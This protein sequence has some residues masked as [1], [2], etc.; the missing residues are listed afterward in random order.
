MQQQSERK[1]KDCEW[2]GT[3]CQG[4]VAD[5]PLYPVADNA[6]QEPATRRAPIDLALER[7]HQVAG[8]RIELMPPESEIGRL[9]LWRSTGQPVDVVVI[10]EAIAVRESS[11]AIATADFLPEEGQRSLVRQD[12]VQH[13]GEDALAAFRLLDEEEPDQ[14]TD[15]QIE[16]LVG[17]PDRGRQSP[18]GLAHDAFDRDLALVMNDLHDTL[19]LEPEVRAQDAVP[20]YDFIQASLQCREVELPGEPESAHH[21]VGGGVRLELVLQPEAAL[22][23]AEPCGLIHRPRRY[24]RPVDGVCRAGSPGTNRRSFEAN[25]ILESAGGAS[26]FAVGRHWWSPG[27]IRMHLIGRRPVMTARRAMVRLTAGTMSESVRSP[28]RILEIETFGRGGLA[29]YAFNL[30][31]ALAE[32]GHEVTLVTAAGFELREHKGSMG[33]EIVEAL[34]RAGDRFGSLLPA[35][36]LPLLRK[37]EAIF[38]AF[39]VIRLARRL[40]PDVIH[41]HCTNQIALLYVALLRRLSTVLV[42]TAHVVMPHEPVRFQR[43]IYRRIH[44][45][46]DLI[47]AHSVFDRRRLLTEFGVAPERVC[48]IPHGEYSFFEHGAPVDRMTARQG[49]GLEPQHEVALFFGYIREYKGLDI[50]LEAWPEVAQ[51]RPEARLVVAGDP[52]QLDPERCRE[53]QQWAARLGV[54]H[55]FG[56][57]PF[58]DVQRYFAAADVLIMPYRHISQSGV[59]YLALSLGLPVVA[60]RVGA[61]AELLDDGDNA[62][63]VPSESPE[64]LACAVIRVLGDA[65]LRERLREGGLRLAE[66]HSWPSIAEQTESEFR[67]SLASS[68]SATPS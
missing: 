7:Q 21:M 48:V 17:D 57:V 60:T 9:F 29:H 58:S 28:M 41:L 3:G 15:L 54:V 31:R 36:L 53:L 59:L 38:D 19:S 50:L 47:V 1:G 35:F 6:V 44:G 66:K 37:I 56:Y 11:G 4:D 18:P 34:G 23:F 26:V 10:L 52:I 20:L 27:S 33:F 64:N 5:L 30:A 55:N 61:L 67:R 2:S 68:K 39:S 63:L 65:G 12:V 45:S 8:K 62:L 14:R 42:T 40:R 32:R 51:A 25:R 49:L 43:S 46:G 22:V 16:R 24:L 13:E